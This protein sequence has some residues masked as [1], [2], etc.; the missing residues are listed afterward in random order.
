LHEPTLVAALSKASA[1]SAGEDH[2][3]AVSMLG[4]VY[5]WGNAECGKTGHGS[6]VVRSTI[7]FPKQIRLEA[8]FRF[9]ACG[10]THTIAISTFGELFTFGGGWFGRLGH[11]TMDNEYT[12]RAVKTVI[13]KMEG[14]DVD[15]P[16]FTDAAC[17]SFHTVMVDDQSQLWCCGRDQLVCEEDHVTKPLLFQHIREQGPVGPLKVEYVSVAAGSAHT[18]VLTR[19]GNLWTW[20]DNTKGQLGLGPKSPEKVMEPC[21]IACKG[22][23]SKSEPD[24]KHGFAMSVS[25]GY[26]HSMA[27]V[28]KGEIWA[29]G[30]QTGGRLAL[31][32][33]VTGRFCSNPHKVE[34]VWK[35]YDRGEE[36]EDHHQVKE[37]HG[38]EE[39]EDG[40]VS[41]I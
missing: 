37:A 16:K 10:P 19:E 24:W 25:C 30:L 12:P 39:E 41:T 34:H 8:R 3:A 5:S 31:K 2:S 22:W 9:T 20:G 17:G 4:E 35:T 29:W 36:E 32:N 14:E 33:P 27:L 26:A 18:L 28:D 11:G 15:A 40:A 38:G 21:G 1:V 13:T 6:S 23:S 7:S